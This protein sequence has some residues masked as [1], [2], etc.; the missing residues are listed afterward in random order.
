M[1]LL[2]IESQQKQDTTQTEPPITFEYVYR[3]F[4]ADSTVRSIIAL[5]GK[6]MVQTFSKDLVNYLFG[7]ARKKPAQQKTDRT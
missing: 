5:L 6:V 1:K 2:G 4:T 7:G 3:L